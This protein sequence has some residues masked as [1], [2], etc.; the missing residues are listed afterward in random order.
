MTRNF[1]LR[2]AVAGL[3]TGLVVTAYTY[4]KWNTIEKM[5]T[6]L[7]KVQV[8]GETV[9]EAIAKTLATLE[10]TKPMIP[11]Y[12]IVAMTVIGALFGLLA[13]YLAT[14]IKTRD[15]VIAIA[16]GLTYTALT[17]A[18]LLA[19]NP[20][21]LSTVL[22]YIPLQEVLLPGITYTIALTLLSTRG[23]WRRIEEAK[24]KIY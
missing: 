12:N 16:T 15:Y 14:K 8:P 18:P 20:Q 10:L 3:V 11:I 21:I 23:P 1:T 6:E 13:T 9:Q 24:P 22:K 5:V 4:I 19:L 7:V 17:T 2:G